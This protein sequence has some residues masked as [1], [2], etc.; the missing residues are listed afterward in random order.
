M[1][2]FYITTPIYYASGK[3]HIGHA[4]SLIYADALARWQKKKGKDVFF[5]TGTDEHGV[6]IA[7]KA[8]D[9][10]INPQEFVDELADIYTDTWHALGIE[11]SDFIR[12]TSARHKKSAQEFFKKIDEAGDIYEGEYE[13]LYCVGCENFVLERNLKDGLCPDHKT[14]PQ[15][16][17]EK[18]FFFNLKKYLP[19]VK[20][21]IIK[22]EIKISPESR[23]NEALSII[24]S[25]IGDFSVTRENVKWGIPFLR[26]G[27]PVGEQTIYVWA[28]ALINY[29]T[30]LDYPNG[31]KF[32]SF[33]PPD[34]QVIGAEIN[35]FH[36]IFWPAL[37]LAAG[38]PLPREIF[39]HGLFTI[40]GQKISKTIG[41]VIDPLDLV[42]KFGADATRYLLLSQFP[43]TEHGDVKAEEFAAKYNSDLANGVGN[44]LERSCKM[45]NDYRA[46]KIKSGI[47]IDGGVEKII[48]EVEEKYEKSLNERNLF[49]ALVAVFHII[50][51]LDVYINEKKP[52]ELNKK[53]DKKSQ[54]DLD[55]ILATLLNGIKK[56]SDL[57]EPFMPAKA[58]QAK[59][60]IAKLENG[61][62]KEGDRLGLFPRM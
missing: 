20:E 31:E 62:I 8:E 16:I 37:L 5:T 1:D 61:E 34:L 29:L 10:K 6:K 26:S 3:P 36:T 56:V 24:E 12:T 45:I 42:E 15:K 25:N 13:G 35:K 32:K 58:K 49:E 33:W 18:N 11:Y 17:K 52:W 54:D 53:E 50:K 47:K 9:V 46:G 57:L 40:D 44:L 2:K 59:D 14:A 4:F 21:K 60:Y 23:K 39:I 38:L 43:T 30:A 41:N 7:Q 55:E 48:I 19:E 28:E 51:I 27:L 22:G